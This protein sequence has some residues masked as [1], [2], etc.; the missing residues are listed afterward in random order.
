MNAQVQFYNFV[1][2][3]VFKSLCYLTEINV[4]HIQ[5]WGLSFSE[6]RFPKIVEAQWTAETSQNMS[7]L[8]IFIEFRW[9]EQ[10]IK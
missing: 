5:L 4:L 8:K 9:T 2:N 3:E 1:E 10:K 7:K 6:F